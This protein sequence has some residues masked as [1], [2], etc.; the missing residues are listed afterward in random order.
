MDQ[1][2]RFTRCW[3]QVQPTVASFIHSLISDYHA[4]EDALQDV[5]V[6]LYRK[7]DTYDESR[8]FV[9]WALG[10]ARYEVM[11]RRR[12]YARSFIAHHSDL[13]ESI[14]E[15]YSEMSSELSQHRK[16]LGDCMKKLSDQQRA[17][18]KM[19]YEEGL[20]SEEISARVGSS[21]GAVRTMLNRIR[22]TLQQCIQHR[23]I[24]QEGGI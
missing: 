1:Q 20:R 17:S 7:F 22:N 3:T 2:E 23:M 12:K 16:Y 24:E 18:L 19:R 10:I 21:A 4:A 11:Q 8:P 13:I 14:A 5:A 6:V 15:T 9:A